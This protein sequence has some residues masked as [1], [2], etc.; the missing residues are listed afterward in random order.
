MA[1]A[2]TTTGNYI[3]ALDS[4][5]QERPTSRITSTPPL[6]HHVRKGH[7]GEITRSIGLTRTRQNQGRIMTIAN[8]S[9]QQ[10]IVKSVNK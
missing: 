10:E 3:A 5:F 6:H 4:S 7:Y 8:A 9:H 2:D 1:I